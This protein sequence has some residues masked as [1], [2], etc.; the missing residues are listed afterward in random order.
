MAQTQRNYRAKNVDMLV[1]ASTIIE[2]A[3]HHKKF[4]QQKRSTW[5]DPFF[6]DIKTR[7]ETATQTYLGVDSAKELRSAT[8]AIYSIQKAALDRLSELKV[9]IIEDFKKDK[10]RRDELL[11]QLG[12]KTHHANAQ[13]DDQ[14][15]LI[16]L[17]FQFKTNM[18]ASLKTEI[19]AK[20]TAEETIDEIISFADSL[21]NANVNQETF[22]GQRKTITAD[23]I[24]EFNEIHAQIISI[25]KIAARFYKDNPAVK[26][27]FSFRKVSK[28][29]NHSPNSSAL[30][31]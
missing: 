27:Q 3:I 7:I 31:K 28:T 12:F 23:T 9:Q 20:G 30:K 1:T 13:N 17:L 18:T 15:A 26:E 4:L 24:K 25:G 6:D 11:N 16:D 8:Q 22:K 14:E 10:V 21:I 19:T 2:N 5:A 29:L